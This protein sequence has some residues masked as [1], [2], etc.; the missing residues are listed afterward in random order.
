MT[1]S[2]SAEYGHNAGGVFNVVTKAGTNQLHGALWEFIRNNHFNA[3]NFFAQESSP[4]LV[5]NQFGAAAG[6]P[7][8]KDKLFVFGSYERLR[9]RQSSLATGA[10]PLTA[11]ER[12]GDLG[13]GNKIDPN[14]FDPVVKAILARPELMPLPNGLGGSLTQSYTKP[15][16]N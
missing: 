4:R 2:F 15:Q 1:S 3:R 16:N 11:A 9:I 6:G 12:A 7:I 8:K 13:G 5:Q 10:F 14:S